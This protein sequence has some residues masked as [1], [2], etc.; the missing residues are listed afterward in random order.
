MADRPTHPTDDAGAAAPA[1]PT[2]TA[3]APREAVGARRAGEGAAAADVAGGGPAHASPAVADAAGHD[4]VGVDGRGGEPLDPADVLDLPGPE[5]RLADQAEGDQLPRAEQPTSDHHAGLGGEQLEEAGVTGPSDDRGELLEGADPHDLDAVLGVEDL[6]AG[7]HADGGA[8]G[9]N[10]ADGGR[11]PALPGTAGYEQAAGRASDAA[12][13]AEGTLGAVEPWQQDVL[14]RYKAEADAAAATGDFDGADKAAAK[15]E[16]FL[17][18]IGA[19]PPAA[20][21]AAEAPPEAGEDVD[22]GVTGSATPV[23]TT[24]DGE[25]RQTEGQRELAEDFEG[26]WLEKLSD[27]ISSDTA[28]TEK[29]QALQQAEQALDDVEAAPPPADP[30]PN[31]DRTPDQGYEGPDLWGEF[32]DAY[33]EAKLAAI[34]GAEVDPD[35][36]ADPGGHV[37]PP[38]TDPT[39]FVAEYGPD[40]PADEGGTGRPI[41]TLPDE[42]FYDV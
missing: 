30:P 21:G 5:Q 15:T 17:A 25:L 8:D 7:D 39:D 33:Q 16:E 22:V 24:A 32:T 26:S 41:D 13:A 20:S 10:P 19:R 2:Q 14:D 11:A 27:F 38:D 6:L 34:R 35:P 9:R 42:E 29:G 31:E 1:R 23:A 12:G 4:P 36:N 37:A 28:A 18:E 3:D 40:V